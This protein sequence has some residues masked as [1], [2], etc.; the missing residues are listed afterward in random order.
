MAEGLPEEI[1]GIGDSR[2]KRRRQNHAHY[3]QQHTRAQFL[4]NLFPAKFGCQ[5]IKLELN[6]LAHTYAANY[7]RVHFWHL[8][9]YKGGR[10]GTEPFGLGLAK[11]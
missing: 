9:V 4:G 5:P 1:N 3:C 2:Q 6:P 11:V 7:V 8:G 10:V